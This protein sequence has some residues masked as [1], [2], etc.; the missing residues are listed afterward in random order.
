M[1][2]LGGG[3]FGGGPMATRLTIAIGAISILLTLLARSG[4]DPTAHL[5]FQPSGLL[6]G[7]LWQP[8]TYAVV[9]PLLR[10]GIFGF[11]LSLYFLY[12]VGS[13]VEAVLGSKRFLGFFFAAPALGAIV[14]TPIAYLLGAPHFLYSGLWAALG[15]LTILFA[16]FF[17]HQPI[18]LMFVLPVQGRT[19]TWISFGIVGLYAL[20]GGLVAVLPAF[21]SMLAALAF[22]RD[23]FQP[24]RA[25][26]RFRAW[27]IERKL[28]RRTG[29]FSVIDGEKKD[30]PPFRRRAKGSDDE[31]GPWL[32]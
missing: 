9:Y 17:S 18:Y 14:A 12:L 26:L 31:R 16:H 7:K 21:F 19:L 29:R 24:R 32:N 10:Y 15:A 1:R 6:A 4:F 3:G 13:Q 23:L 28:K 22:T 30:D 5:L 27:Q 25:W 2:H 11:L 20:V 8:L